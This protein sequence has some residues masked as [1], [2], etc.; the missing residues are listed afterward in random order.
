MDFK[1][2]EKIM[3]EYYRVQDACWDLLPEDAAEGYITDI[4]FFRN[5]ALEEYV[6]VK[7]TFDNDGNLFHN[8]Y[9]YPLE[10]L[11]EHLK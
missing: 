3:K 5:K 11:K 2:L 10:K 4:T 8:I 9:E 1:K 7:V 6:G